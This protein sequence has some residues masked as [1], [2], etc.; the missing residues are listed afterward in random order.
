M[1][2]IKSAGKIIMYFLI[3]MFILTF[4]NYFDIINYKIFNILK[5]LSLFILLILFNLK[6]NINKKDSLKLGLIFILI[7]LIFNILF[8]HTFN[9]KTIIYYLFILGT[10]SIKKNKS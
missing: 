7:L 1:K 10:F 2:L 5:Y 6:S 8:V 4:L 3:I 9:I